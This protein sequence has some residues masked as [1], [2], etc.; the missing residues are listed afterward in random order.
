MKKIF[1]AII[2]ITVLVIGCKSTGGG[3]SSGGNLTDFSSAI[4]KDLKL[5]Q[6]INSG[7][8]IHFHRETLEREGYKD[9]FTLKFDAQN[10]SGKGAPNTY[11]A[12]YTRQSNNLSIKTMRTTLMAPL[13]Q[14]ENLK[15]FDFFIYMQNAFEW[16]IVNG[17]ME[18]NSRN[19]DGTLV[20]MLFT[21]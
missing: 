1:T 5:I 6:V 15:E 2:L 3:S 8:N 7:R 13:H 4:G 12:P 18:I 17:R 14:P 10:V 19:M 20:T 9:F 21:L 16:R 11:S